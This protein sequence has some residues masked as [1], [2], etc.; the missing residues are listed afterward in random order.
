MVGA[1]ELKRHDACMIRLF[2]WPNITMEIA[3]LDVCRRSKQLFVSCL[4]SFGTSHP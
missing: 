4:R 3:V 2:L 1:L